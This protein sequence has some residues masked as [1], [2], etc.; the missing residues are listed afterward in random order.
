MSKPPGGLIE[1]GRPG[2]RSLTDSDWQAV[3]IFR[4][5]GEVTWYYNETVSRQ[6]LWADNIAKNLWRHMVTMQPWPTAV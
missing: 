6:N 1:Y 3:V 2:K 4:V 5:K